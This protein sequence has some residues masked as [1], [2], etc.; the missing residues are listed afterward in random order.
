MD[1]VTHWLLPVESSKRCKV[2]TLFLWKSGKQIK[3]LWNY[4]ETS[5]S[6]VHPLCVTSH[7]K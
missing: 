6:N 3:R 5:V 7:I 2:L 1:G 4:F